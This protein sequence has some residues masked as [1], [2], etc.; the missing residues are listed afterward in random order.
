LLAYFIGSKLTTIQVVAITVLYTIAFL[1]NIIAQLD[2]MS[3]AMEYR[4]LANEIAADVKFRL[5]PNA[6]YA[7]IAIRILVYTIS[8]WFMWDMRHPKAG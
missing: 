2:A 4:R 1:I 7:I 8:L 3:E 6:Q 5:R